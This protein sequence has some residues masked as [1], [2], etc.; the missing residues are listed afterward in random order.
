MHNAALTI[1]HHFGFPWTEDHLT[2]ND[3]GILFEKSRK[4]YRFSEIEGVNV[5]LS[6]FWSLMGIAVI[7]LLVTSL[8][9]WN[10]LFVIMAW[11][12]WTLVLRHSTTL[13]ISTPTRKHCVSS[14][15]PSAVWGFWQAASDAV[16]QWKVQR[17]SAGHA[18]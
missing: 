4:L 2:L 1:Y 18:L 13:T 5:G 10:P 12:L 11:S 8:V 9:F 15:N 14:Y 16:I 6:W 7:V 17:C 3:E